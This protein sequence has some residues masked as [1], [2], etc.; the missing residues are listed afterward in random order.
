MPAAVLVGLSVLT[1]TSTLSRKRWQRGGCRADWNMERAFLLLNL[2]FSC[3]P[4][5]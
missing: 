4:P 3:A 1:R 2:V 5:I